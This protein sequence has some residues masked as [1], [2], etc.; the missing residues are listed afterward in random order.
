MPWLEYKC[1]ECG[2]EF[3][4]LILI[5]EKPPQPK[6]PGCGASNI[7]PSVSSDPLFEGISSSSQLAGDR[8]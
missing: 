6:C 5:G 2:R 8:N 4:R 1:P 3:K 7:K